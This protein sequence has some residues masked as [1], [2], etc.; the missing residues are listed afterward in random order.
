MS[1]LI[2]TCTVCTIDITIRLNT[3]RYVGITVDCTYSNEKD[4]TDH[5]IWKYT[6]HTIEIAIFLKTRTDI[7]KTVDSTLYIFRWESSHKP[8]LSNLRYTEITAIGKS[9]DI[10]YPNDK[11]HMSNLILSCIVHSTEITN[12]FNTRRNVGT[13]VDC[14]YSDE[15]AHMSPLIQTALCIA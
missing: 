3:R 2:W 8:P 5:F 13:I 4:H 14:M 12:R 15:I 9:I 7:G 11:A 10:T 1:H 6:V